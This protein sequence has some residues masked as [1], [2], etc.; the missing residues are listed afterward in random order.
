MEYIADRFGL[1]TIS[2]SNTLRRHENLLISY[3]TF[4][5]HMDKI[6]RNKTKHPLPKLN[7]M[8]TND[9]Y[10]TSNNP[11]I[12]KARNLYIQYLK[13][14]TGFDKIEFI[15]SPSRRSRDDG[16]TADCV[17]IQRVYL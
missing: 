3:E 17:I 15:W 2:G 9:N 7:K 1:F 5:R 6:H 14:F 16:P 13:D 4:I 11:K 10:L 12:I 8:V